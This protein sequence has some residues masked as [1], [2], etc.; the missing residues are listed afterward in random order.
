M[1]RHQQSF[2][3]CRR[4]QVTKRSRPHRRLVGRGPPRRRHWRASLMPC[5][6]S[7]SIIGF[8]IARRACWS[9]WHRSTVTA[10]VAGPRPTRTRRRT[11]AAAVRRHW[12]WVRAAA[13]HCDSRAESVAVTGR[14]AVPSPQ[15]VRVGLSD[16][17]SGSESWTRL[18]L[19][20]SAG[21]G[22]YYN[23]ITC[24]GLKNG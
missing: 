4:L 18:Y 20:V 5:T 21:I 9:P 13:V 6:A 1:H 3:I 10:T 12:H 14:L 23:N 15:T 24:H 22:M 16:S 11:R 8:R 7:A 2:R 19:Y 17:D